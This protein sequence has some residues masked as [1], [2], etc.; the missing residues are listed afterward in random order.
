MSPGTGELP[1]VRRVSL[2]FF[3]LREADFEPSRAAGD[4]GVAADKGAV[5]RGSTVAGPAGAMA[6]GSG[7]A[8]GPTAAPFGLTDRSAATGAR[9]TSSACISAGGGACVREAP[10][11]SKVEVA[12]PAPNR[13]IAAS[14]AKAS[15]PAL[16]FH[17]RFVVS[18]GMG[19]G[20]AGT[21]ARPDGAGTSGAFLGASHRRLSSLASLCQP[22]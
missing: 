8:D 22:G 13:P 6:E 15:L 10:L 1:L 21:S 11:L 7:G 17:L 4:G 2:S 3:A 12:K 19:G 14:S 16:G 9:F 18:L 5:G 20:A